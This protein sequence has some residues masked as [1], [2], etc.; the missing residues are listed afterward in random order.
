MQLSNFTRTILGAAVVA[1]ALA[2]TTAAQS[3]NIVI[4]QVY[5]G[6]GNSGATYRNDFVELFNL[7]NAAY[8]MTDWSVQYTSATGSSWGNQMVVINMTLQPGQHYLIMLQGGASG[9][10]L[11][12]PDTVGD[13]NLS[14]SAGKVALVNH[15]VALPSIWCPGAGDGVVDLVGYGG[16]ANCYE[17]IGA[18]PGPGNAT[19]L[20]R[21]NGGCTD[22]DQNSLD[23]TLLSPVPRNSMAAYNLCDGTVTG[24]CCVGTTCS[25]G[26][27]QAQCTA[28]GGTWKG[29]GT[30]CSTNPCTAPTGACCTGS[31]CTIDTQQNCTTMGHTYSGNGTTCSPSPCLSCETIESAKAGGAGQPT[32]LCDVIINNKTDL[33]SSA[34]YKSF[35]VQHTVNSVTRGITVYGTN[36]EID[37]AL[38]GKLEGDKLNIDG[39]TN[40]Y[41]GLFQLELP[42]NATKTGTPGVPAPLAV[43]PAD[44]ANGSPTAEGY[45]SCLVTV[46]C[47]LFTPPQAQGALFAANTNYLVMDAG[48]TT[49]I[50]RCTGGTALVGQAI[51]TG[52]RNIKGIFSQF[53]DNSPYDAGYQLLPR[54]IADITAGSNCGPVIGSCC[55]NGTCVGGHTQSSCTTAGG[56][57][58]GDGTSCTPDP[59]VCDGIVAAKGAG[60][61]QFVR[62]C[63]ATLS[64]DIDLISSGS[65]K[66]IQ[67]QDAGAG[68]TVYGTNAEID[69]I[70]GQ[71]FLYDK[72]T[73]RGQTNIFN[74]LFE[75]SSPVS[76]ES[77]NGTGTV[78]TPVVVTSVDFQTG[79]PTAEAYESMWVTL[80]CATFA[81]AGG[82]FNSS[83]NYMV[84][85]PYGDVVVRVSTSTQDLVGQPIPTGPVNI[86]G[87]F[88][89][90]DTSSPY[91]GGYQLLL[92]SMLD[93]S[94]LGKIEPN[95]NCGAS[96]GACC[97]AG[98]CTSGQNQASC[99]ALGGEYLGD[100][101]GCTPTVCPVPVMGGDI[102]L[103]LSL[104][105]KTRC[106]EH[107]RN[108]T[109]VGGWPSVAYLQSMEFDN[110]TVPHAACGNLLAVDYGDGGLAP[111]S[112]PD[113][114]D[115]NRP[116]EAGKI[117][118]LATDGSNN[119]QK[120][121]D[122]NSLAGGVECTRVSGLSVSPN[123]NYLACWGVDMSNLYVL[124]YNAGAAPGSGTGVPFITTEWIYMGLG[125]PT[126]SQGTAWLDPNTILVY[127]TD[128]VPGFTTLNRI[129]FNGS[130]FTLLGS[131]I[132]PVTNSGGSMFTDVDYNSAVSPYVFCLFSNYTSPTAST[133]ISA[134][135]PSNWSIVKTLDISTVVETGR[136]IALGP[137]GY[138]YIAQ[139]RGYIDRISV[140][141]PA[142]WTTAQVLDYY[143]LSEFAAYCGLDVAFDCPSPS[144][145]CCLA[146][147]CSIRTH[148]QC[149]A[150]VG[151]FKGANTTC[152][153]NP[154]VCL[155]DCNCDGVIDFDDINAFVDALSGGTPCN[156][157]NCDIDGNGYIDFNDINPFVAILS[158]GQPCP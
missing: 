26:K 48:G 81:D 19:A 119:S 99:A 79:S 56:T 70:L 127:N 157:E 129:R 63:Q 91:D 65:Y 62:V 83:T 132:V 22:T 5:G 133:Y 53:D 66:T 117:Y 158:A 21:L 97:V 68:I 14:A 109:K 24:A 110:F 43:T 147:S 149:Q 71:A 106:N 143:H 93:P 29:A 115:P 105:S 16:T 52:W 146:G 100:G 121:Y 15:N 40:E 122:F 141:N 148:A 64:N 3:P 7:S 67:L 138:L 145:A 96:V 55:I 35:Q 139:Y 95:P 101:T 72:V 27:T 46:N 12:T 131:L 31:F 123:N 74:G 76:F 154:C 84:T 30:G 20:L 58:Q 18:A 113:C 60:G 50:V 57:Y 156:F 54:T 33:V 114:V 17:G 77:N 88:S 150:L 155:G 82:T 41:N 92:T 6:G 59:C 51:P 86:T 89:Q 135:N 112:P 130:T 140:A 1:L 136:E 34:S 47:V 8:T 111:G 126:A 120:V 44:F 153:P 90:Y 42:T 23:F 73:V 125:V 98:S 134:I 107:V 4:S 38:T 49:M 144:G 142:G 9:A 2:T 25:N 108:S 103:G 152:T 36:A 10:A 104:G 128:W 75:L 94:R 80:N 102:A 85:D 87:I 116:D 39:I 11:P 61:G 118:N 45:E 151:V 78:P 69:A 137:D 13:F 37:A 28:M 32:R 124:A